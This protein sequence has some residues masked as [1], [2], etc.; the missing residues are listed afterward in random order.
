M[1]EA[2]RLLMIVYL[3]FYDN[4]LASSVGWKFKQFSLLELI[5]I[6]LVHIAEVHVVNEYAF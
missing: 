3:D 5:I 1:E 6:S 4:V 2:V